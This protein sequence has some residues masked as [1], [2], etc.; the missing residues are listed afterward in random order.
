MPV[1]M[2]TLEFT[3]APLRLNN[4]LYPIYLLESGSGGRDESVIKNIAMSVTDL[5]GLLGTAWC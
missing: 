4:D 5:L 2:R 3:H 1:N